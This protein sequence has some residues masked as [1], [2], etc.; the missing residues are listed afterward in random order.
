MHKIKCQRLIL[1]SHFEGELLLSKG[2]GTIYVVDFPGALFLGFMPVTILI[3]FQ[4]GGGESESP[5]VPSQDRDAALGGVS[6]FRG[7]LL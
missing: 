7:L 5:T 6:P 3:R 1:G 2:R 4:K